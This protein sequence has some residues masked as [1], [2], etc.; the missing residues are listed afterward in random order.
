MKLLKECL[1]IVKRNNRRSVLFAATFVIGVSALSYGGVFSHTASAQ[2]RS[3]DSEHLVNVTTQRVGPDSNSIV[4]T[5]CGLAVMIVSESDDSPIMLGA[6]MATHLSQL[7]VD[8]DS[9]PATEIEVE[10]LELA[11]HY[12]SI[13]ENC[14][15]VR[16]T[17]DRDA[18]KERFSP[19]SNAIGKDELI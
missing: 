13:R 6:S 2:T 8:A 10:A 5:V 9:G 18:M 19:G 4:V 17:N 3:A 15:A 14:K 12:H 11:D 7:G 1:S 16:K